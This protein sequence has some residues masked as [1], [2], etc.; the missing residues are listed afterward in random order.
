MFLRSSFPPQ[1]AGINRIELIVAVNLLVLTILLL[2]PACQNHRG[3]NDGRTQSI[4]NLKQIGLAMHDFF[5][6]NKR[7]PF[8]GIA[9]GT[10]VKPEGS[11]L[12]YY[13]NAV[14]DASS[15]GSWLFQILP[16]LD[17][18]PM[19]RLSGKGGSD[20]IPANLLNTGVSSYICPGR[21]R[22][23][24]EDGK[25]PWSDY[26]INNYLNNPTNAG[27]PDGPDA[28]VTL[29]SI[30]DGSS[31]TIFAGHGNIAT[32]DYSKTKN[33]AGSSSIFVGGTQGTMR[34]GPAWVKGQR[35]LVA[36]Q[37]D[38]ATPV[39]LAAGGWGG[40]Y[41]IGALMVWCDATVRQVS[42][43]TRPD[44]VGAYM[45][46]NGEEKVELPD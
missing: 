32:T 22:Q 40:P 10:K 34:G 5:D 7:L 21:I 33:V 28:K 2:I 36:L 3:R 19:Y 46:P 23:S 12:T 41:P 35:P 45:T 26:F 16:Y 27:K 43:T 18:V 17:Q 15:S 29:L 24:F 30:T 31:N 13:G 38:S 11:S 25:G 44:V 20:T 6:T 39:V 4:N 14:S 9:P 1:R 8:N 37:R 42:Y